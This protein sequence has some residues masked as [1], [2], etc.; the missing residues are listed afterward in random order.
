VT[1]SLPTKAGKGGDAFTLLSGFQLT[2][3]ELAFNRQHAA[4]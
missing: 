3:A 1:L 2:P 4:R